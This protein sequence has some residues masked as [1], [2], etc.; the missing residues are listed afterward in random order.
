MAGIVVY[1]RE[2]CMTDFLSF[3][4]SEKATVMGSI[5]SDSLSFIQSLIDAGI[6]TSIVSDRFNRCCR[7]LWGI[8]SMLIP[9]RHNLSD[10]SVKEN[11]RSAAFSFLHL[12]ECKNRCKE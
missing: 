7:S 2:I 12:K 11:H 9:L 10:L 4:T 3:I 1:T 8:D 5:T 6:D